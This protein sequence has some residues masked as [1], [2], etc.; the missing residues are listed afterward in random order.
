VPSC[1]NSLPGSRPGWRSQSCVSLLGRRQ[2][3]RSSPQ[4]TQPTNCNPVHLQQRQ[5]HGQQLRHR[6]PHHRR[7]HLPL[8]ENLRQLLLAQRRRQ[9]LCHHHPQQPGPVQA[10]PWEDGPQRWSRSTSS[11]P[12]CLL[13]PPG[14]PLPAWPHLRLCRALGDK[15]GRHQPL[16]LD[17]SPRPASRHRAPLP[18]QPTMQAAA[19]RHLRR[20]PS[21]SPLWQ[22]LVNHSS[23]V[24]L[25]VA[26]PRLRRAPC[27]RLLARSAAVHVSA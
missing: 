19:P 9:Q 1:R 26:V 12:R 2:R 14:A 7:H 10:E 24:P 23:V 25:G 4:H 3:Q 21:P 18:P 5:Q 17:R 11:T 27:C 6:H 8:Q 13:L 16:L 15:A 20:A 22:A